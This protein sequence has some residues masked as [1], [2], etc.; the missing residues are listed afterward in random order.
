MPAGGPVAPAA[1]WRIDG[2]RRGLASWV[3][4]L[5]GAAVL[6]FPLRWAVF[7]IVQRDDPNSWMLLG[8]TAL[9]AL[10]YGV[11]L[12]WL[13]RTVTP[14]MLTFLFLISYPARVPL[15]ESDIDLYTVTGGHITVGHF[16]F[17]AEGY[18]AFYSVSLVGLAG[19]L[20]GSL[21]GVFLNRRTRLSYAWEANPWLARLGPLCLLWVGASV[22]VNL[23]CFGLG[24]GISGVEPP[25]LP[26]HLTGV[27]NLLRSFV[28]PLAGWFVFGL[29]YERRANLLCFG[30]LLLH[31]ALGAA[32]VYFTLSKAGLMYAVLPLVAYLVLR[33]PPRA[34]TWKILGGTVAVLV[35][36]LPITYFGAMVLRDQSD[37]GQGESREESFRR[38]LADHGAEDASAVQVVERTLLHLTS[39]VTGGSELM[40][41]TAAPGYTPDV[42]LGV[43]AGR[44]ADVQFGAHKMF[45]DIFN[46]HLFQEDGKFSGKAF[47]FFGTLYL[48]HSRSLVFLGAAFFAAAI[49]WI[50]ALARRHANQ[51]VAVGLAFWLVLAVWESGFDILWLHPPLLVA[52]FT[53][54]RLLQK[55][56]RRAARRLAPGLPVTPNAPTS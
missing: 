21:A 36:L 17:S 14:F 12:C 27:L 32:A 15:I 49:T 44:A 33:A 54:V 38:I 50:E 52:L 46:V 47:G 51:A 4:W 37:G 28:L 11:S 53:L 8:F 9:S 29:A 20:C 3:Y 39:R 25:R 41:I 55:G 42:V 35:A 13:S 6:F 56:L 16:D 31:L 22:A 26:L 30:L 5:A 18:R 45:L 2:S 19:L 24:I 34:F 48:S 40:A 1:R 10:G 43:V 23:A 7:G